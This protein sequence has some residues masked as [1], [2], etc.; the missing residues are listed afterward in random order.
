[1]LRSNTLARRSISPKKKEQPNLQ[2]LRIVIDKT[3]VK[4]Y[5]AWLK[6]MD[7]L[8]EKFAAMSLG[9]DEKDKANNMPRHSDGKGAQSM[10][11]SLEFIGTSIVTDGNAA[12]LRRMNRK[13][14]ILRTQNQRMKR[15]NTAFENEHQSNSKEKSDENKENE[16]RLPELSDSFVINQLN[17]W[18]ANG[19]MSQILDEFH[20]FMNDL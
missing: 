3:V 10:N 16:D 13:M 4:E 11:D 14:G 9:P 20:Q 18:T 2:V 1:M 6:K 19:E 15:K 8:S 12:Q 17:E 7:E 5:F